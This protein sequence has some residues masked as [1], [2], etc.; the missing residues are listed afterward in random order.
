MAKNASK[1]LR[2]QIKD[3]EKDLLRIVEQSKKEVEG[4]IKKA[5]D[6]GN[7]ATAASVRNGLYTGIVSEYVRL[8]KNLD[9]WVE[10]QTKK[11]AKAWH[12]LAVDDLPKGEGG[13]FGAF[14]KKHLDTITQNVSPSN[15]DKRVLLNP[16]IGSMAKS[17]IDAVR[18]AVTDTL[19]KGALTGLTTPQMAEEMKKAV[20][21]IK[22]SLIIR[23]K[24]GR[25][26]QTDAYFAMLN[27]T[28][29]AN[30]ARETYNET[31]TDAG[32]DLRQVEGG[33][34]AG[35]LEPNDPCSR[36]AGKILSATG[37]TKG[38]PT[39]AEAT[40][41]G[42]FHVN[43]IHGLSVVTPTGLPEAKKEEKQE[44]KEGA[45]DRAKV[46]KERKEAG[47][48]PAKF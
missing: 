21:A 39:V 8:N 30:V 20:G 37:A 45:K 35:S 12:T 4:K 25:R 13:T 10:G 2:K 29:T 11:T 41:D 24:N 1:I 33:I 28:V 44:A 22:P 23:D 15:V 7:F 17:D 31:A 43:C 34:T 36:W 16:R 47:L 19:R 9:G 38:Y 26:M 46:Q 5:L 18:V 3:G 48:K 6:K 42:L 40:A 27:R 32:Y 14:S